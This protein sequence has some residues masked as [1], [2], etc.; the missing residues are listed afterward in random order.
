MRNLLV[1]LIL[2]WLPA[3]LF[4][5]VK[6]SINGVVIDSTQS[7]IPGATLVLS[8][9]DTGEVR[10]MTSSEQG[11]FNF[12]DLARGDY[13][14]VVKAD[15]FR[16]LQMGPLELTVGE[17]MTVRPKLDVG[18]LAEVVEV[19]ST[20]PPVTTSTSSVSQLVD[21]KRIEQLPLNG[22]NALQLIALLPGVV[23]AGTAGQFGATQAT[24]STSGGRNIDM[25]FTLDGGYNMNSF[26]S[27]ANEYPNPDALQEV[28]TSTRNYTAAFGRG[29]SSVA[30]VTRSGTNQ[31]HGSAFEFL[32]NTE[33]DAR[34]F[35]SAKRADFK[36]NQY[37]HVRR[38]D[39]E[40]PPVLLPRI[41]GHESPGHAGRR[42]VS[43]AE[44]SR[45]KRRFLG[46]H[47]AV[48]RSG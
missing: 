16:E 28:S 47:H 13:T 5:Q 30:A 7:A 15:G 2:I 19:Q 12:V 6:G 8:S 20:A 31:F 4:A 42:A 27:I 9:K 43:D 38:S 44:H 41:S 39:S 46:G 35:F 34:S 11:Y 29:T 1:V 14:L 3:C 17:Q 23:N 22:R 10:R 33:L 24:F 36:R 18:T 48:A 37:G 45:K 32:R 21:S 26:Y 25:N 40:E